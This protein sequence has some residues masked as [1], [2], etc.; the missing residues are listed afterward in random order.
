MT[1]YPA[2]RFDSYDL[3]PRRD[4]LL[5]AGMVIAGSSGSRVSPKFGA[6]VKLGGAFR[7]FG[8]YA[9]GFKAPEPSQVNQY[10]ENL[11]FGYTSRPNPN[12][13]P[14]SSESFEGGVRYSSDAVSVGITAFKAKYKDF[15]SQEVV[16]GA[17]TVA[18]PMVYQ[19]I[20]INRVEVAGAEA[21]LDYRGPEGITANVALS[22]AT[23]DGINGA[24]VRTPL[25][26]IDPTKL[27]FGGGYRDPEGRFGGQLIATYS[28]QKESN[29]TTGVCTAACYTPGEFVILDAT[30]FVRLTDGVTLRAGVFNLFDRKYAWWNDVRG[31]ASTSTIK[32]AYT[33]PG[34]NGSVSV[35]YRF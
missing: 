26:T 25:S 1:L 35:S 2:L 4:A 15:I 23:G 13:K 30:A 34:R 7:L 14:E 9:K 16:A 11:A 21:R 33:Q 18:N 27:V 3:S 10:F 8:N 31:V 6:V 19:F 24:G 12:L 17:G 5:P 32:D 29:R 28:A 22:Y 20:N